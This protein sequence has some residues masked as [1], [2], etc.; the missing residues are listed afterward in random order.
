MVSASEELLRLDFALQLE[1]AVEQGLGAGRTAR[2]IDIHRN[3]LVDTLH[4]VVGMAERPARNGATAHCDDVFGVGHLVVEPFEDRR[5]LVDDGAGHHD[6]IG[7]TRTGAR[8]F[9]AEPREVVAGGAHGHEF[10]AAA[11]CGERQ[12]PKRVG[13]SPVD[14]VVQTAEPNRRAGR[15]E[16]IQRIQI[17]V[18]LE[19][20]VVD[21]LYALVFHSGIR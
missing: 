9:E 3:D 15:L 2:Y 7:L 21:G 8:H 10:Y 19:S 5:H 12:R 13:S 11:A 16:L 17:V 4:H 18:V 1:H 20:C 14:H 6:D